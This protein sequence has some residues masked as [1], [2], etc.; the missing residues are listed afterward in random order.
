MG[1]R[2]VDRESTSHDPE[3]DLPLVELPGT[4]PCNECGECCRYVAVEIDAPTAF[5]DYDYIH[6]YLIHRDV[7]V[8]EDWDGAW[9]IEFLTACEHL[10]PARTCGIYHER[11]KICSSFSWDECE[12]KTREPAAKHRFDTYEQFLAW[13]ERRRPKQFARY[14]AKRRELVAQR[15]KGAGAKKGKAANEKAAGKKDRKGKPGR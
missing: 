2:A 5:R 6:W 13:L 14:Q 3:L 1:P 12:V 9:F 7:S 15:K 8:Y 10:T 4:H 11:P